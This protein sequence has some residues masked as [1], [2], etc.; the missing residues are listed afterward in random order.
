M[1]S[2]EFVERLAR[3]ARPTRP[4]LHIAV[5]PRWGRVLAAGGAHW[6]ATAAETATEVAH[7]RAVARES[8]TMS[9][10]AGELGI[11]GTSPGSGRFRE[12]MAPVLAA[13]AVVAVVGS[14]IVGDKLIASN[15]SIV[16]SAVPPIPEA[17]LSYPGV[18]GI[19][20][21]AFSPSSEILATAAKAGG[22]YLWNLTNQQPNVGIIPQSGDGSISAVTFSPHGNILASGTSDGTVQLWNVA[23]VLKPKLLSTV[24][25]TLASPV[26]SIAFSK[27]GNTLASG[28]NPIQIWDVTNPAR[29]VLRDSLPAGP[30][31]IIVSSAISADGSTA[32]SADTDG[33]INLWS[34][35][36]LRETR[37]LPGVT[38]GGI[39]SLVFSP[40]GSILATADLDGSTFLWNVAT[41]KLITTFPDPGRSGGVSSVAFSPDGSTLAT[42][43]LDGSTFLWNAAAW[44]PSPS[45]SSS[46]TSVQSLSGPVSV[47]VAV[48]STDVMN[49]ATN[50]SAMRAIISQLNARLAEIGRNNEKAAFVLVYATGSTADIANAIQSANIVLEKLRLQ[51]P[52]FSHAS[53]EGLW[54]GAPAASF[55]EFEI[56]FF[57]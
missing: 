57:D 33:R 28:G 29:P 39:S 31:S 18:P 48:S 20:D 14:L 22:I 6:A 52:I 13:L 56:Y 53:G 9:A 16:R 26:L 32:A 37:S 41:G 1:R 45:P 38:G 35:A 12:F 40:D 19:S 44:Y 3:A 49:P 7:T 43:D 10:A 8:A 55:F 5:S 25:R 34:L 47:N 15:S 17:S 54:A 24:R 23:N 36:Q 2:S 50:P 21:I 42:A 11:M 46:P 30:G 27:G 4:W 51:D